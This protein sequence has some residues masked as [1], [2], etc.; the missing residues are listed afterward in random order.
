MVTIEQIARVTHET[1]KAYC[2]SIGDTSQLS[3]EAAPEWQRT[4]AINGVKFHINPGS[5]PSASHENWLKEKTE[6]GW[7]Y[8]KVKDVDKKEHPCFVPYDELPAEQKVKDSLFIGV[9][10]AMSVLLT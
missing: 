7:K 2:D 1:N 6:Q 9:V 5:P 3:W 8:G 4:S 10:T